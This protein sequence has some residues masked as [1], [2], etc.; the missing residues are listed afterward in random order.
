MTIIRIN[1]L[2]LELNVQ[3]DQVMEELKKLEVKVKNHMS[4]IDL[5]VANQIRDIFLN[6]KK[7]SP[8]ESFSKTKKA[9]KTKANKTQGCFLYQNVNS[10]G[11]FLSIF[12][13]F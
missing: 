7:T 2:A 8:K 13:T 3:N 1:K 4:A 12:A 10:A 9:S 5:D 11:R 6:T